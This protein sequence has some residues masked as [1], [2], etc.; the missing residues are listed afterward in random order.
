MSSQAKQSNVASLP[1]SSYRPQMRPP[2]M[3]Q[4]PHLPQHHQQTSISQQQQ[5]QKQHQLQQ[6]QH[7]QQQS[8]L[9]NQ[10][11]DNHPLRNQPNIPSQHQASQ[12]LVPTVQKSNVQA[13]AQP[14]LGSNDTEEISNDIISR[15][16]IRELVTQVDRSEKLRPEIEDDLLEIAD[17]F[18][19]SIVTAA[20]HLAKHR[21]ST[22][23]EAKDI[24]V[25][26]ERHWNMSLPG[27]SGDEIKC[28]KKPSTND[29]HKERLAMV[30]LVLILQSS[31]SVS[32][33][34]LSYTCIIIII[35]I[36]HWSPV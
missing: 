16:R 4:R 8:S 10:S 3:Q 17:D 35:I 32:A 22:T 15:K 34:S 14:G 6:I 12:A 11:Q 18:I 24:L 13:L 20:C 30:C 23:L 1:S 7:M 28:Y 5:Q 2:T 21:K 36:Y 25:H 19:E 27:F 29:I 26:V 31:V 33:F 9:Q